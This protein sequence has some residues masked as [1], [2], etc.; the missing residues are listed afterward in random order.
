M[1]NSYSEF[2]ILYLFITEYQRLQIWSSETSKLD[3]KRS[4]HPQLGANMATDY[5]HDDK[6]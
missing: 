1:V 5:R 4:I 2:N 3:L 6:V